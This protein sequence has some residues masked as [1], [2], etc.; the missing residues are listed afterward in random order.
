MCNTHLLNTQD[1]YLWTPYDEEGQGQHG[2]DYQVE[3]FHLVIHLEL[4]VENLLRL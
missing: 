2:I 3:L 4:L 1:E